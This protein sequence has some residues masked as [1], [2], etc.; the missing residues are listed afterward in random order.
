MQRVGRAICLKRPNFHLTKALTT[1]LGLTTQR[2]L[3]NQAVRAGRTRVDFVVHKVVQFQ[4]VFDTHGDRTCELFTSPTIIE[5][6]LTGFAEPG[7][8]QRVVHIR[9]FG[10]VENR[11]RDR[12][13]TGHVARSLDQALLVHIGDAFIIDIVA[14][15]DPH[16]FANRRQ[17]TGAAVIFQRIVNLQAQTACGPTHVGFKDLTDVHTRR[18]TQRVQTEVNRRTIGQERHVFHRNNARDHTLVPVTTGHLIARLKLTLH[19]DKDFDHF[20]HARGQVVATADFFDLVLETVIQ[21]TFLRVELG[22]QSFDLCGVCFFTQSQ[23]PPLTFGQAVQQVFGDLSV[24]LDAFGAFN[25]HFAKDH[26]LEAGVDVALKDRQ[27]VVTV[28]R[29]TLDFFTLNLNGTFVFFHTMAVKDAHLDNGTKVTRRQTQGRVT[30]IRR[31]FTEDRAQQFL[32]RGHRAFTF[33]GDFAHQNVSRPNLG[34]DVH[35]ASLV[36]VAQ[37]FFTDVRDVASDLFRT[38]FRVTGG[39]FEFLNVD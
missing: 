23:L 35:D 21:S 1:E 24:R 27:F 14:I 8:Q 28:T 39:D 16:C 29:Q 3:G 19:R 33:G 25:G 10:A 31:L 32:F 9:L 17:I 13:T 34:A 20:H 5:V 15:G 18:H 4:Q 38:Q 36:E 11:R 22:V 2:L 6:R 37:R 26:R 12:N 30:H 7:A